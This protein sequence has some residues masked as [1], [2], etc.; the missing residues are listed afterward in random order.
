[1][2]LIMPSNMAF[3]YINQKLIGW[4][5]AI[6]KIATRALNTFLSLIKTSSIV[7]N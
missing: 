4:F 7:Q 2:N 3:K 5:Y 6:D 1:M